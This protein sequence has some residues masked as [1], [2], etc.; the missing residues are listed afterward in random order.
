M[1]TV[2]TTNKNIKEFT[3][4]DTIYI[5]RMVN[6]YQ[7]TH[8]CKF[9]KFERGRVIGNIILVTPDWAHHSSLVGTEMSAPIKKC[10]LWDDGGCKW[11]GA[12]GLI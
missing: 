8:F 5:T 4:N 3:S 12:D 7:I 10:F 9:N 1:R 2:N 6:G 11:F